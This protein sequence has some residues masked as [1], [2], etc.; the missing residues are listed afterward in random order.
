MS[1][2]R[3][4]VREG[5]DGLAAEYAA[6]RDDKDE[7]VLAELD[8]RLPPDA[9]VLDAGCGD[10]RVVARGVDAELVGLDFSRE[11]LRLAREHV[12]NPLVQGDM[13]SLPFSDGSFD[14]VAALYSV[15]HVPI[16]EHSAVYEEF[17]RV[18][19]EG[20]WLL[21]TVGDDAWV[22]AN[23]DWL[24]SGVRMEW[25]FPTI[26]E[27][28]EALSQAGFEEADRWTVDDSL[29]GEFPFVLARRA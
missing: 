3:R 13:T 28:V 21:V 16:G 25:S 9:R 27:S 23:D 29:G 20:G 15:I 5:Y 22:G 6:T 10:G 1:D 14:A 11:Q 24:D 2:Q 19:R 8:G 12:S 4:R 7:S 17:A 26:E 18:L